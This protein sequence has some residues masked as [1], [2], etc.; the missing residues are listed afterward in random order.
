MKVKTDWTGIQ[1]TPETDEE[2]NILENPWN[3]LPDN[4]KGYMPAPCGAEF[5]RDVN[6]TGIFIISG[7]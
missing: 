5:I 7:L 4:V 6:E 2:I 1:L 3:A